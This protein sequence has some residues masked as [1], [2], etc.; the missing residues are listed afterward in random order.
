M[1]SGGG[2]YKGDTPNFL[3]IPR[4]PVVMVG[5]KASGKSQIPSKIF[6]NQFSSEYRST[7]G[8]DF[9]IESFNNR[10]K[11]YWWDTSA[12]ERFRSIIA[13]YLKQCHIAILCIDG[14][15]PFKNQMQEIQN[16][17]N[18][19]VKLSP[20]AEIFCLVTKSDS[21]NF[22]NTILE[23]VKKFAVGKKIDDKNIF[24]CSA[25]KGISFD[26]AN[27]FGARL[28]TVAD[29]LVQTRPEQ[30]QKRDLSMKRA[31]IAY[32]KK[33]Y[34]ALRAG[35]TESFFR[36]NILNT[37]PEDTNQAYRMLF[38]TR[39]KNNSRTEKT[40]LLMNK[41]K[42]DETYDIAQFSKNNSL[43]KEI[44]LWS[45]D[46]SCFTKSNSFSGQGFCQTFFRTSSVRALVDAS[47]EVINPSNNSRYG[48]I[49][50]KL[51]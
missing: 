49:L 36:S 29:S 15:V 25:K 6:D 4:V 28:V 48:K 43:I 20:D 51:K 30:Q 16:W 7:I 47:D 10:F 11:W 24:E 5:P 19:I 23:S 1:L 39:A 26:A 46:N 40:L 17:Y 14:T 9:R 33:I 31:K 50:A 12:E 41:Y 22:D 37:L 42:I 2:D 34:S 38:E 18:D 3:K 32:F 45:Y 8:V 13:T 21:S 35:Q 44:Y 27:S